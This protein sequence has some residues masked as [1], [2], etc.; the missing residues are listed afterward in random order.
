MRALLLSLILSMLA[1]PACSQRIPEAELAKS[2]PAVVA[3]DIYMTCIRA[4]FVAGRPTF[5]KASELAEYVA[6][7]DEKCVTW[8]V[9]WFP[10]FVGYQI[11]QMTP[12]RTQVF[13]TLRDG[14]LDNV[15]SELAET[16]PKRVKK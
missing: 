9:V 7:L 2:S 4:E 11:D 10:A 15:R 3:F 8:T 5:A 13:I 14:V 12:L 6:Y 1:G 16:L